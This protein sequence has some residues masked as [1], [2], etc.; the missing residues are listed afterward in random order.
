MMSYT[1]SPTTNELA[2]PSP[3]HATKE[4]FSHM[5]LTNRYENAYFDQGKTSLTSSQLSGIKLMTVD[6]TA[7]TGNPAGNHP[8]PNANGNPESAVN[9]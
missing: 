1:T 6:Y 2:G 5:T 3:F 8:A 4:S 7:V 9:G